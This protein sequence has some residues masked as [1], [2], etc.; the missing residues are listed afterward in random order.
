MRYAHASSGSE[1]ENF[2]LYGLFGLAYRLTIGFLLEHELDKFDK[3]I[4]LYELISGFS[5]SRLSIQSNIRFDSPPRPPPSRN[6]FDVI[7]GSPY[8]EH[9]NVS[10]IYDPEPIPV[11]LKN[12]VQRLPPEILNNIKLRLFLVLVKV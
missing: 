1:S 5:K 2:L 3:N 11:P 12:R 4:N 6:S 8:S 10:H 9:L 7:S